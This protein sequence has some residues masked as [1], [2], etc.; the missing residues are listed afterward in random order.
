ML[1][2]LMGF[3]W[4]RLFSEFSKEDKTNRGDTLERQLRKFLIDCQIADIRI[5]NPDTDGFDIYQSLFYNDNLKHGNKVS[6]GKFLITKLEDKVAV[7]SIEVAV[8][9]K[10]TSTGEHTSNQIS[11][12]KKLASGFPLIF[13]SLGT[14]ENYYNTLLERVDRWISESQTMYPILILRLPKNLLS[15]LLIL[16]KLT[17][18]EYLTS[19]NILMAWAERFCPFLSKIENFFY[20][21]PEKLYERQISIKL[22]SLKSISQ[23]IIEKESDIDDI[24]QEIQITPLKSAVNML[25]SIIDTIK[26]HKLIYV[27]EREL[28]K[29]VK[30]EHPKV[31]ED[32]K[33]LFPKLLK[34][35]INQAKVKEFE[36][37][38]D[39]KPAIKKITLNWNINES[40]Q[41]LDSKYL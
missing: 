16:G 8:E 33:I 24:T 12:I 38:K 4:D 40:V 39:K 23:E 21:L 26:N 41:I 14:S 3:N 17:D 19:I 22:K 27:L 34:E 2:E 20:H 25:C 1:Q 36:Y 28:N 29:K 11:K 18:P 9:I 6:D 13:F 30:K 37:G 5:K 15:P 31:L 7:E 32:F 10:Y 35:L